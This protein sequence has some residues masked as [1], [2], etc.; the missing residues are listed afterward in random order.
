MLNGNAQGGQHA[1]VVRP[2]NSRDPITT[3]A[4]LMIV[5]RVYIQIRAERIRMP[6]SVCWKPRNGGVIRSL[7]PA[8]V[9]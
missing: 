5:F 1:S 9:R 8:E 2:K 6:L 3:L 4:G 7:P